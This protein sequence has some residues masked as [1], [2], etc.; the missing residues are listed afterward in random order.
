MM[1]VTPN[2]DADVI[3]EFALLL[4]FAALVVKCMADKTEKSS[5]DETA[6]EDGAAVSPAAGTA[7]TIP[8]PPTLSLLS[9]CLQTWFTT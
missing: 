3:T 8:P 7:G 9:S 5:A 4:L 6:A 2:D 1:G